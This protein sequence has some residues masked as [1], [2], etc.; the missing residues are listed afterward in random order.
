VAAFCA[1][2][3]ACASS[4]AAATW[5]EKEDPTGDLI[6]IFIPPYRNMLE[7]EDEVRLP[8]HGKSYGLLRKS[9]EQQE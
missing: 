5:V 4:L 6:F 8:R 7:E 9:I 3:T 2:P 1:V